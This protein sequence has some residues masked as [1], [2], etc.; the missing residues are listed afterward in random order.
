[1]N[2]SSHAARIPN[3]TSTV[4]LSGQPGF[5]LKTGQLVTSSIAEEIEA[6]FD[7]VEAALAA[8]GVENGLQAI[9]KITCYLLDVGIEPEVMKVWR[10]RAPGHRPVWIT[11]GV[12]S[13]AVPGMH[14][15]MAPEA[16][17]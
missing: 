12:G 15:E 6:C 2:G 4:I 10:K 8:A 9:F 7:C 14:I 17:F 11:I 5:N 13:L 16:V 3:H 1:V